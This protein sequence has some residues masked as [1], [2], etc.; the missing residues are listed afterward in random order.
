LTAPPA[1]SDPETME[2]PRPPLLGRAPMLA[3]AAVLVA[4]F[5]FGL[6]SYALFD[7]DEGRNAEVAREMVERGDFAVPRL[8][9]LPYLDKPMLFFAAEA[10]S[11][12]L[13][14]R[15]EWSAR[16]PPLLFT[17]AT[18]LV[19]AALARRLYGRS[20]AWIAGI[21]SLAAP[22]PLAY[23]RTVIFDSQLTL[24]LT[25]S[26]AAFYLATEAPRGAPAALGWTLVGWGAMGL[27]VLAKGPVALAVPLL[28]VAPYAAV[29][30]RS[31]A[32]WHPLGPVLLVLLVAPWVAVMS[33][34]VPGF[35]RYALLNETWE[36]ITTDDFQRTGPF[37]YFVPILLVGA[38]PWTA[39]VA[40]AW[41]R[42][43]RWR[44]SD[45]QIDHRLL[46]LLLWIVLP[47]LLFSLSHS[48]RPH[49]I[50]PLL[51]AVAILAA[52][53]WSAPRGSQPLPGARPAAWSWA[54]FGLLF[55]VGAIYLHAVP[56]RNP[57]GLSHLPSTLLALGVAAT[58]GG[59]VAWAASRRPGPALAAL[60]LPVAAIPLLT[61]PL[62]EEIGSV[63][64]ARELALAVQPRL[65]A[66]TEVVAVHAF[67]PS[68]PFYL[69]RRIVVVSGRGRELTSNYVARNFP[70]LLADPDSPLRPS[71]WWQ[72]ALARCER[73]RIFV[74]DHDD[75][76]SLT[77]VRAARLPLIYQGPR[78]AAYG[79]CSPQ[80]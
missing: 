33:R 24:L 66:R 61:L 11:F 21:A 46:F 7:P 67:P 53:A 23:S 37:W 56:E 38:L 55:F 69:G 30:R 5:A 49:Y 74:L 60:A 43:L 57:V 12:E 54:A 29:R 77:V 39:L 22:L 6:G 18:S 35:L 28:A 15:S 9:G 2:E 1:P 58:V 68:L 80:R 41:R 25:I 73:P 20:A 17:L 72:G 47:F 10:T 27:G 26:L 40:G 48:K 44:G 4:A 32:V 59:G 8:D 62:L 3:L 71:S 13:F 78:F 50:L 36:R 16:L 31:R 64:S 34:A 75:D 65:E 63:R 79:P 76:A 70:Q 52:G 42:S 19:A 45:G 14:G 51:P